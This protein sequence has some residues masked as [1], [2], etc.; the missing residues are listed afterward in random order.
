MVGVLTIHAP[1]CYLDMWFDL[2]RSILS[3]SM[4]AL[5]FV[6][7]SQY[8]YFSILSIGCGA[9]PDL[10]AFEEIV[11]DKAIYYKGYDR[12]PLWRPIHDKLEAMQKRQLILLQIC[13]AKIYLMCFSVDALQANDLM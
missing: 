5:D 2:R 4:I 7:I 11:E 12:N 6:D 10:M 8:P 13:N 3:K 9:A 1:T